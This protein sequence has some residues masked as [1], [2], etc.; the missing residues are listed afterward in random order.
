MLEKRG[1]KLEQLG[2]RTAQLE[3]EA[4]SFADLARQLRRNKS[5]PSETCAAGN[6]MGGG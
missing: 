4:A 3:N 1:E 2:E 6:M 5:G